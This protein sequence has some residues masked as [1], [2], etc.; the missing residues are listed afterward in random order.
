MTQL[1]EEKGTKLGHVLYLQCFDVFQY[2]YPKDIMVYT[3]T[4]RQ[5]NRTIQKQAMKEHMQYC[6]NVFFFFKDMDPFS[7]K[8]VQKVSKY[9][10]ALICY[11]CMV[12]LEVTIFFRIFYISKALFPLLL[13]LF[14]YP[15]ALRIGRRIGRIDTGFF[16]FICTTQNN[17]GMWQT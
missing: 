16:L 13:L 14:P 5:T 2:D 6:S 3:H 15:D 10:K 11:F 12:E 7:D 1:W 9:T 8:N 17:S 4:Q